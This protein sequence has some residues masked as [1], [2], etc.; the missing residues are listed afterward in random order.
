MTGQL[1][2]NCSIDINKVFFL[3]CKAKLFCPNHQQCSNSFLKRLR[4]KLSQTRNEQPTVCNPSVEDTLVDVEAIGYA[5]A[6]I[7]EEVPL[8]LVP[9]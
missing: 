5:C 1:S 9:C 8:L 3:I 7:R 4:L 2:L 6:L